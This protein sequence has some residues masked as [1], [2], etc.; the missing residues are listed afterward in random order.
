MIKLTL[1][2]STDRDIKNFQKSLVVIGSSE[3]ADISLPGE[4][5][6]PLH[7]KIELK[8]NDYYIVN[9]AND[10]FVTL[11]GIPFGRKKLAN[12]DIIQIGNTFIQFNHEAVIKDLPPLAPLK[13]TPKA[14]NQEYWL[15]TAEEKLQQ[16]IETK[17]NAK[18]HEPSLASSNSVA[19]NGNSSE[20]SLNSPPD[21]IERP[22][23][24]EIDEESLWEDSE[25]QELMNQANQ[26][27]L[28]PD[29]MKST[30]TR[31]NNLPPP[32]VPP[33]IIKENK[34]IVETPKPTPPHKKHKGSLKDSYL[35]DFDDES[36]TWNQHKKKMQVESKNPLRLNFKAIGFVLA[37]LAIVIFAF[38]LFLF[39]HLRAKHLEDELE[40]GE[41]V[42]DIAM[43]L[44]F[45]QLN[46]VK[47]LNQNWS[48][49]DFLK[50]NLMAVLASEYSPAYFFENHGQFKN[51]EYSL[52]IYSSA[53]L[54]QFLII[55][56]PAP[57][58]LQWLVPKASILV[59]SKSME[60]RRTTDLK[61]LNKL[62]L[63]PNT[64]EGMNAVEVNNLF[65]QGEI[66]SFN[67]LSNNGKD[68]GYIFARA[69]AIVRPGAENVIYNAPRYYP[70]SETFLRKALMITDNYVNTY[71]RSLIQE[72]IRQ[73]AKYPN[74]VFYTSKGM[75]WL[76]KAQ[77][78]MNLLYPTNN[79]LYATIQLDPKGKILDSHLILE[80]KAPKSNE[81]ADLAEFTLLMEQSEQ[82]DLFDIEFHDPEESANELS[83][84]E[85]HNKQAAPYPI[86]YHHP[87]YKELQAL[88]DSKKNEFPSLESEFKKLLVMDHQEDILF[89]LSNLKTLLSKAES[90]NQNDPQKREKNHAA[91]LFLEELISIMQNYHE[92]QNREQ[93]DITAELTRLRQNYAYMPLD[94]FMAYVEAI[95]LKNKYFLPGN[96]IQPQ[97]SDPLESKIPIYLI[98]IQNA[99]TLLDLEHHVT[100]LISQLTLDKFSD[101]KKLIH[102]QNEIHFVVLEKLNAFLLS[103]DKAL[104]AKEFIPENRLVLANILK[105]AWVI[106]PD[107][108]D[109]YLNEFDLR[110]QELSTTDS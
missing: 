95:G 89:M 65:K 107:E 52:R 88:T 82:N 11:N 58:L 99:D 96:L 110:L 13:E 5:L 25:L 50:N 81:D 3:E 4:Y 16:L 57:S 6:E 51:N 24:E 97:P 43:A 17:I 15:D 45:A 7:I 72:E 106:D 22:Q 49:P 35:S 38:L 2:P 100:Q 109:F 48:D 53:D 31:E 9:A 85:H 63:N 104:S 75:K 64:L 83:F 34:L 54:S 10:P 56:Q 92:S 60:I 36:E 80:N 71:E 42:A 101:T 46:H 93:P 73:L 79:F 1:N 26:L 44:A 87:L 66:M 19:S 67:A 30:P 105:S 39:F 102:Y 41:G 59:D 98:S 78:A 90:Q 77:K 55:A 40:A 69:L 23:D 14:S 21:D 28:D 47:P 62:L 29:E 74:L 33:I 18:S 8:G 91:T 108:F 94:D 20:S 76:Q 27:E 12:N 84:G 86:D 37:A 68:L 70:F 103:S 32:P 61:S